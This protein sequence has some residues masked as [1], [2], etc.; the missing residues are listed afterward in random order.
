MARGGRRGRRAR[1]ALDRRAS[2]RTSGEGA[3][4]GRLRARRGRPGAPGRERWRG[5]AGLR[6]PRLPEDPRTAE[7]NRSGVGDRLCRVSDST[8]GTPMRSTCSRARRRA[9]G[10]RGARRR[11]RG[12]RGATRFRFYGSGYGHGI[13]MSQW[14]AYGLANK[15]WSLSADPHALLL[16]NRVVRSSTLPRKIRVGLT[17]G[18]T[19]IHLGARNGPVRL[20]MEGPGATFVAKIPWGKT[21]TVS[22][23]SAESKY[24][25]RDQ[26]A[27]SSAAADGAARPGLC[28]P[29]SPTRAP[30]SS[31]PRRTTSGTRDTRTPTGSSSSICIDCADRCAERLTIELPF[32]KYL[33]GMGEMPSSWPGGAPFPGGRRPD[34]RDLQDPAVRAA[35]RLQLSYRRQRERSGLRGLQG[36][37]AGRRQ[38]GRRRRRHRGE[39][40]TYGGTV[41]QAFYAASDGGHPRTSRTSGTGGTPPTRSRSFAACATRAST[42]RP[43][44]GRTGRGVHASSLSSR[45]SPYTGG[46]GTILGSRTSARHL[47][48]DRERDRSR[49]RRL[50]LR[51]GQRAQGR[52][53]AARRACLDQPG[54]KHRRCGPREIRRP[55]VPARAA[56]VEAARP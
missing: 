17:S 27:R 16:A 45:L 5:P 38:V 53:R 15:G 13:G 44:R 10:C 11:V 9:G 55:D 1:G 48:S 47:R 50:R 29:R 26:T 19:T 37:R 40:V 20:W 31:C 43:T 34:V 6:R 24:A 18:R 46:I 14:G 30:V 23:A 25:I 52:A 54:P 35:E 2:A 51:R 8:L 39:V 49:N 3:I 12:A 4:A 33:R 32:E 42:R 21:W 7:L 41:I 56:G 22:A 28:S 36:E